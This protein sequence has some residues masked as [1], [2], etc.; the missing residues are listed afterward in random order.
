MVHD[1]VDEDAVVLGVG[2]VEAANIWRSR[3]SRG[4]IDARRAAERTDARDHAR[5]REVA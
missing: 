2:E 3:R 4:V 5:G 1:L